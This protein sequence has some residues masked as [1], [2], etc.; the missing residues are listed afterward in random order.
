[1][2]DQR[3]ALPHPTQPYALDSHDVERFKANYI[4]SELLDFASQ[5]GFD[6]NAIARRQYTPEDRVQ[7]AQLIGYS[8][9]G[10]ADLSYVDQEAYDRAVMEGASEEDGAPESER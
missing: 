2:K 9:S 8:V 7:F 6:M 1:M 5:H 10:F 3:D 4:V